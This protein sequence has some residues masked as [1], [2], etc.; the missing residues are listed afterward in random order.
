V[1]FSAFFL[2]RSNPCD[3]FLCDVTSAAAHVVLLSH[4][5]TGRREGAR[6]GPEVTQA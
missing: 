1:H 6:S 2:Y 4:P 5:L 3:V